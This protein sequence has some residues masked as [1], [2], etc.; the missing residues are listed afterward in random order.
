MRRCHCIQAK[1]RSTSQR[2]ILVSAA[3][4]DLAGAACGDWNDA[5]R[6]SS[7]PSVSQLL[8]QRIA[9]VGAIAGWNS[10]LAS[11]M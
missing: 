1:K 5:A 2:R 10:G 8:I 11:I 3:V 6:S 9:V 4:A 7:M